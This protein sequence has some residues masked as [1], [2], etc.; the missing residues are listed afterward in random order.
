MPNQSSQYFMDI[1]N[2][3]SNAGRNT[4]PTN[5]ERSRVFYRDLVRTYMLYSFWQKMNQKSES[6]FERWTVRLD[7]SIARYM[8]RTIG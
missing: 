7:K 5:D 1:L 4:Q 8:E 6:T 3:P 2:S